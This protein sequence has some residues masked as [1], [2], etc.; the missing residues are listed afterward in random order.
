VLGPHAEEEK[1]RG[2]RVSKKGLEKRGEGKKR[3]EGTEGF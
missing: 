3:F 2:F 1:R